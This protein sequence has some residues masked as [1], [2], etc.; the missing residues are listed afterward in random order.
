MGSTYECDQ[1]DGASSVLYA[2]S[3]NSSRKLMLF[4]STSGS[5]MQFN[6]LRTYLTFQEEV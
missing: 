1:A 3:V 2:L 5:L 4:K 6:S